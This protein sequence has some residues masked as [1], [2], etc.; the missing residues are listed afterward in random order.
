MRKIRKNSL[1]IL[2]SAVFAINIPL[3]AHASSEFKVSRDNERIFLE[4]PC[5]DFRAQIDALISW[6]EKLGEKAQAEVKIEQPDEKNCKAEISG[7]LTEFVSHNFDRDPLKSQSVCFNT[8]LV[9]SGVIA[10]IRTSNTNEIDFW[11]HSDLCRE[12]DQRSEALMPGDI[13]YISQEDSRGGPW[14]GYHAFVYLTPELAFEGLPDPSNFTTLKAVRNDWNPSSFSYSYYRCKTAEEYILGELIP[15]IEDASLKTELTDLY[16]H[17]V[18]D[19]KTLSKYSQGINSGS[20]EL[21]EIKARSETALKLLT[22][23]IVESEDAWVESIMDSLPE[24][25]RQRFMSDKKSSSSLRVYLLDKLIKR[26]QME[27]KYGMK[28]GEPPELTVMKAIYYT[29]S[30]IDY[31][32]R[33]MGFFEPEKENRKKSENNN[34]K[35]SSKAQNL[36]E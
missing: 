26:Y 8:A 23:A 5:T 20:P 31:E 30:A 15:G 12:V 28:I 6:K 11:L 1:I 35:I 27:K 17:S 13:G 10:G 36:K 2:A 16:N 9:S 33:T 4:G 29:Y 21:F 3:S 19:D 24:H 14:N 22:Q 18:F 34:G 7:I 32:L 25:E